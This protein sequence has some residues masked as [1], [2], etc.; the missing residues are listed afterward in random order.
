M[1]IPPTAGARRSP[2]G[3]VGSVLLH[4]GIVG[5]TLFTFAHKLQIDQESPPVV[6]VE[7][8]TISTK[9][10]II[11]Q[12][13]APKETPKP[14]EPKP[15]E[16][17]KIETPPPQPQP[18]PA[19]EKLDVAPQ[20]KPVEEPPPPEETVKPEP[21]PKPPPPLPEVKPTPEPK[22]ETPPKKQQFD[23]NKVMA[24]LD[25]REA[26][27]NSAPKGRKAEKNIKGFGPQ[28]AMT[29]DLQD[30]LRNQIQQCWNPP[31]GAPHP[32]ELVVEF[33][34]F[35]KSDGSVARP[36]QLSDESE[37]AVAHDSFTRAAAEA[38]RRAIYTCAPYKL[39]QDRYDQWQEITLN[40]DPRQMIDQ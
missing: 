7:L 22:A 21:A 23:I 4:A 14:E 31:V 26:S 5:A 3:L 28:T 9:T 12:V 19:P 1:S 27:Q 30:S 17:Q 35:L 24:L 8:V 16:P 33:D 18:K 38:A 37:S 2:V 10:N 29:M 15:P 40:F 34:L 13:K 20:P 25:K 6:P 11:A 32:E 36:P 39:P